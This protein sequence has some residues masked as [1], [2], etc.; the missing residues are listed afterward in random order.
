[1]A[2]HEQVWTKVNAKVDRGVAELIA[3]LSAFPDVRTLESCEG[4]DDT[5][6]VCF[7][8]GE[9]NWKCLSE[10]V[11]GVLGPSLMEDFGGRI[12]LSVGITESGMYRAEM[13]ICKAVISAVSKTMEQ[14]PISIKTA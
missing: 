3:A 1:M 5:A 6:W 9:E 11:F 12:R 2:I 4:N 7:D 14:L 8:C 13:T 10:F